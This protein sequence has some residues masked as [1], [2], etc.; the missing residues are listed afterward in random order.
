MTPKATFNC[1]EEY[2]YR[3]AK[4]CGYD[5][6]NEKKRKYI[7]HSLIGFGHIF[8]PYDYYYFNIFTHLREKKKYS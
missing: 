1:N 7:R 5:E 4:K 2:Y 3:D 6:I 8:R